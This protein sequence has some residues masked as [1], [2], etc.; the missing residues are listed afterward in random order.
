MGNRTKDILSKIRVN[1]SILKTREHHIR[2]YLAL[3]NDI[4]VDLDILKPRDSCDPYLLFYFLFPKHMRYLGS[5]WR[6]R[7]QVSA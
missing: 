4:E 7:L 2:K 1:S 5:I 6:K 3:H